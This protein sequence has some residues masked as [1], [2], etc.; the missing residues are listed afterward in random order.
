MVEVVVE[1][2]VGVAVQLSSRP[3]A[4]ASYPRKVVGVL[5]SS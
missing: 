3:D 2:V 4:V 5:E 1:S